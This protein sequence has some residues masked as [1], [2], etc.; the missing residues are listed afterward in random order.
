MDLAYKTFLN[1]LSTFSG[2]FT[3]LKWGPL[4]ERLVE[5]WAANPK[6]PAAARWMYPVTLLLSSIYFFFVFLG[7]CAVACVARRAEKRILGSM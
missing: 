4:K 7:L 5:R 2:L 6:L 3:A 1:D